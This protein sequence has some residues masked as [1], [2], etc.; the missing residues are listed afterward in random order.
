[1]FSDDVGNTERQRVER[2][3]ERFTMST[4]I[5]DSGKNKSILEKTQARISVCIYVCTKPHHV[6]LNWFSELLSRKENA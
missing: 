4:T 5:S 6:Y 3:D 2:V 1:L